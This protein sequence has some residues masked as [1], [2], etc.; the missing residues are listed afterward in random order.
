MAAP[1]RLGALEGVMIV[2]CQEVSDLGVWGLS[3]FDGAGTV[4][5]GS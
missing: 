4:I 1:C 3:A 5:W 2:R